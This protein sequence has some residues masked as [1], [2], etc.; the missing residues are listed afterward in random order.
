MGRYPVE[1]LSTLGAKRPW[2]SPGRAGT[3]SAVTERSSRV[4]GPL[5]APVRVTSAPLL[6]GEARA[7]SE[8]P[9]ATAPH[10]SRPYG[11][12]TFSWEK[13]LRFLMNYIPLSFM[14]GI[15]PSRRQPAKNPLH[16]TVQGVKRSFFRPQGGR[17]ISEA[18]KQSGTGR[19]RRSRKPS[20]SS[21]GGPAHR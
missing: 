8:F 11:R 16:A 21:G 9:A 12:A 5:F 6:M 14:Y 18:G 13:A 10:P 4:R 19:W 2:L 20:R 17:G 15:Y 7:L 3:A 1:H